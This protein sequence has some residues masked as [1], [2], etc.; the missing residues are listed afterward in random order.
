MSELGSVVHFIR[1]FRSIEELTQETDEGLLA[2][3]LS[4]HDEPAFGILA[5]RHGPMILAL[6]RRVLGD[7]HLAEDATQA[8][9]LVL[10]RK[11]KSIKR[12]S[13]LANWLFGVAIRTALKART[14][15]KNA[16]RTQPLGEAIAPEGTDEFLWADLRPVL[17]EEIK[18]LPE[19]YRAPFIL[20]YL[21][22]QSNAA[23]AVALRCPQGTVVTR[24]ARAR[25]KLR[26]ALS[27]RGISL[28]LAVFCRALDQCLVPAEWPAYAIR[29]VTSQALRFSLGAGA[30]ELTA[31]LNSTILAK[32]V[33]EMMSLSKLLKTAALSAIGLVTLFGGAAG[34]QR[35]IASQQDAQSGSSAVLAQSLTSAA[36]YAPPQ[37]Q[38]GAAPTPSPGGSTPGNTNQ[39]VSSKPL[40][41]TTFLTPIFEG[42]AVGQPIPFTVE[43]KGLPEKYAEQVLKQISAP[44]EDL[45]NPAPAKDFQT[46]E[47][48]ERTGH[49]GSAYFL[50]EVICRRYPDTQ[51]A[52]R[53]AQRKEEIIK[54]ALPK[55]ALGKVEPVGR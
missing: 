40:E 20:C 43:I 1:T 6:C 15:G 31:N 9:F 51:L 48:Y 34:Y 3:F 18:R 55:N 47:F 28:S 42:G 19:K 13:H 53:A 45:R 2:R 5:K 22:G 38:D 14:L 36:P 7:H 24:L 8:T 11:A 35:L 49:L 52:K 37:S 26:K 33:L 39:S 44:L 21:S 25:A 16:R 4:Q 32:G 54:K 23:A 30:V 50:Y 29:D 12:P 10:A 27:Q 17:D 46:A 41:V